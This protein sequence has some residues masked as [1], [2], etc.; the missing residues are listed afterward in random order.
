MLNDKSFQKF[1]RNKGLLFI[2]S[3]PSGAGKSTMCNEVIGSDPLLRFSVSC[4]TRAP[5]RGEQHGREYF[6]LSEQ[7]FRKKIKQHA[8]VEWA[9]VH[10]NLYGTEK[11]WIEDTRKTYDV[12]LDIDVQGA[13]NLRH[14]YADAVYVFVMPPSRAV[15]VQ[16]LMQRKTE[17]PSTIQKRCM[18]ALH[19]M[20]S[21]SQYDYVIYNDV[22]RD[23]VTQLKSVVIAERC[24]NKTL[25]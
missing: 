12:M 6:F 11:K 20:K 18:D 7:S 9:E 13:H 2:I 19:E 16:R 15:L 1:R 17:S 10:G 22:L 23:A 4:T 14:R 25:D 24:R 5:R 8:F 21:A 3:G